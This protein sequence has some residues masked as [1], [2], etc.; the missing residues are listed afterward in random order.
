ME[1]FGRPQ[2]HRAEWRY[3]E[4]NPSPTDLPISKSWGV[5]R[6]VLVQGFPILWGDRLGKSPGGITR[7]YPRGVS[8]LPTAWTGEYPQVSPGEHDPGGNPP[9][10]IPPR[11]P[12]PPGD[13]LGD[14]AENQPRC[15]LG[16][17]PGGSPGG[18]SQASPGGILWEDS[19][20]RSSRGIST[21][22][23]ILRGILQ[24]GFSMGDSPGA[25]NRPL[26]DHK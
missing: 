17:L 3:M 1:V 18:S 22:R 16:D 10:G 20:G 6:A 19:P 7:G 13:P 25:T 4:C 2:I 15:P 9:W 8:Q 12:I 5:S 24:G 23:G 26:I 21:L 14:L 11:H